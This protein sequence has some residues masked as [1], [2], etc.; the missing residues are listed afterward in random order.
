M[1]NSYTWVT[2]LPHCQLILRWTHVILYGI[3]AHQ[4]VSWTENLNSIHKYNHSSKKKKNNLEKIQANL[5]FYLL[6]KSKSKLRVST[7]PTKKKKKSQTVKFIYKGGVENW[8]YL[9]LNL[10]IS[11]LFVNALKM[12]RTNKAL[13]WLSQI[14]LSIFIFLLR[15]I[16][17]YRISSWGL[18]CSQNSGFE[19]CR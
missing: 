12:E 11:V 7:Q 17:W 4:S 6:K 15:V 14:L 10:I 13:H 5:Y 16:N 3:R 1:E 9:D 19:G 8:D 18:A 2:S